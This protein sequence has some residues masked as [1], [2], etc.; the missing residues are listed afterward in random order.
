MHKDSTLKAPVHERGRLII[1]PL[2]SRK[3]KALYKTLI[4]DVGSLHRSHLST[5]RPHHWP[6]DSVPRVLRRWEAFQTSWEAFQASLGSDGYSMEPKREPDASEDHGEGPHELRALRSC[7]EAAMVLTLLV[8]SRWYILEPESNN[9]VDSL[10]FWLRRSMQEGRSGI[11]PTGG[12]ASAFATRGFSS[13]RCGDWAMGKPRPGG[14]IRP[15]G[16][17]KSAGKKS[18]GEREGGRDGRGT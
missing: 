3:H 16:G 18:R 6:A 8:L 2:T 10:S 11:V 7:S 17:R 12:F 14:G 9:K 4:A 15:G 13:W 1:T 5:S